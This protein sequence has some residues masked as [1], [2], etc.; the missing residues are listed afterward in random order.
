MI[1][2]SASTPHA[3]VKTSPWAAS[4]RYEADIRA[5]LAHGRGHHRPGSRNLITSSRTRRGQ[6]APLQ[7]RSDLRLASPEFFV[8]DH[9][10][11]GAAGREN[12]FA[13]LVGGR[14]IEQ[15]RFLERL[16][17]VRVHHFGPYVAVVARRI[18]A[19]EN[20]AEVGAAIAG[21]D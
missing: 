20:V 21:R 17:G 18:T 6:T 2:S 4:M 11:V 10:V 14:L 13:E 19:R 16:E 5:R 7:Q 9:G 15:S 3:R 8:E 1:S 12:V